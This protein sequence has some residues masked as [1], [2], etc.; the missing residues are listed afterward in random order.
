MP[1]DENKFTPD[2]N[3]PRESDARGNSGGSASATL[4]PLSD[5]PKTRGPGMRKLET[6]LRETYETLAVIAVMPF[7]Q[8]A[9]AL[10]HKRAGELAES[11][12]DLAERDSRIKHTLERL[13]EATGWGG[14]VATHAAIIIPVL[15]NRGMLPDAVAGGAAAMTLMQFPDLKPYF[16]H[17]RWNTS[18]TNANGNGNARA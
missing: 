11:W 12:I 6:Q 15:A 2:E 8:L 4:P 18:T 13:M 9:G 10:V 3:V 7:D 14:V 17:E 16:T 1:A 5:T